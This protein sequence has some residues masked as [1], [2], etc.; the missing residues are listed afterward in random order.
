[1]LNRLINLFKKFEYSEYWKVLVKESNSLN[2][3]FNLKSLEINNSIRYWYADPFLF[4]YKSNYYL[5]VEVFDK[6]SN[7]GHI[8]YFNLTK[9]SNKH[10]SIIIDKNHLSYPFIFKYKKSI[11]LIPESSESHSITLYKS[12]NFPNKW[13]K[14]KSILNNISAVDT[15]ILFYK[16]NIYLITSI[17]GKDNLSSERVYL[18]NEEFRIIKL[19]KYSRRFSYFSRNAGMFFKHKSRLIRPTQLSSKNSYGKGIR[20]S[21]IDK[22][23]QFKSLIN[24]NYSSIVYKNS[25]HVGFHTI[26]KLG[27]FLAVDIKYSK[28]NNFFVKLYLILLYYIKRIKNGIK[29]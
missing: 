27:K 29:N 11:Y 8:G 10:K 7:K 4:T 25:N 13:K 5:F 23:L 24:I 17:L 3:N 19:L 6:F 12:Y 9:K 16:K 14:V 15:N 21:F 20:L 18:L 28:R 1:M 26:S 22:F 2:L